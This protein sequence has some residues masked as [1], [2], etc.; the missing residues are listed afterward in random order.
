MIEELLAE[1][2]DKMGRSLDRSRQ[3]IVK[4]RVG[5]A[6]ASLLD[7]IKVDYFG[8]LMPI[9]QLATISTPEVH[10]LVI[11]PWDKNAVNAIIKAIQVSDLGLNPMY[12]GNI[13]RVPI[14][15]LTEERRREMVKLA[16]RLAEEGRVALRNIRREAISRLKDAEKAGEISEDDSH[17]AMDDVQ[18]IMDSFIKE[19]DEIVSA[20]EKEIMEV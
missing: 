8:S 16:K 1:V 15:P 10:L 3:E 20:K 9:N 18:E 12:D 13:I 19:L 17:R 2:K 5:K 7:G 6:R 4:L 11:Q 14:P